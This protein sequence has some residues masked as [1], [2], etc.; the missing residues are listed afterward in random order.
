MEKGLTLMETIC[1]IVLVSIFTL[2][3]FLVIRNTNISFLK[4]TAYQEVSEKLKIT[5]LLSGLNISKTKLTINQVG[6][7][8]IISNDGIELI[9]YEDN[10][11][12][13]NLLNSELVL[14]YNVITNYEI[15]TNLI[16]F[17]L[18]NSVK[19]DQIIMRWCI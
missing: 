6:N 5:K 2:F 15:K 11:L 14:K 13:N 12:I 8:F 18:Q 1:Y 10:R 9:K 4:D 16:I 3:I 19:D 17:N 7:G